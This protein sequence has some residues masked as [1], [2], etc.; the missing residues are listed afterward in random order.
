MKVKV[1]KL[2][3]ILAP[4]REQEIMKNHLVFNKRDKS[5]FY[6]DEYIND[7]CKDRPHGLYMANKLNRRAIACELK[8]SYYNR[9]SRMCSLFM[10][11]QKILSVNS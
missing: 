7:M 5:N 9:W 3:K 1:K 10:K 6:S 4:V 11:Y 2:K 8:E